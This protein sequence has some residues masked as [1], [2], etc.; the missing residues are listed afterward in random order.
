MV[1]RDEAKIISIDGSVMEGGG[2]ILRTATALSILSRKP[3]R[4]SNI[5]ANRPQPG[6]RTQHLRGLEAVADMCGGRLE[7]G[8]LG[9]RQV[10][11]YPG[12][13]SGN[14]ISINIETAGSVG[15]ILQSLLAAS[16]HVRERTTVDIEGGATF[17]KFAPPL[18]YIQFVLLPVLR[19]MGYHAEININRHGFYPVGG[20]RVKVI[21]HPCAGLKS[22]SMLER[23]DVETV[24]C[25]SVASRSL[26]KPRVAER[27]AR[28]V[29]EA[30]GKQGYECNVKTQYVDS[31]CP[32]SGVVLVART[33]TGCI[34]GSDGLGERG[35]PAEAV[36]EEAVTKMLDTIDSGAAVDPHMSDQIL[37]YMALAKERSSITAPTLTMHARTN[38]WAIR[39]FL[40]AEFSTED[41]NGTVRI[42]C[43]P[44]P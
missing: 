7:G 29:T 36:A 19:R 34:I 37:P 31:S 10:F 2:Q 15:L 42:D 8:K 4:I 12:K 21:I 40:Q 33:G 11:F 9:S 26:K 1:R 23:G 35:K 25:I 22:I 41:V 43:D 30:I 24:D 13:I 39:Q 27:Q 18:H 14:E 3:V 38:I 20:A 16:L 6:L 32:G 17:G 5:R 28:T 44:A